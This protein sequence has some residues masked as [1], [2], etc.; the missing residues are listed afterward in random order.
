MIPSEEPEDLDQPDEMVTIMECLMP[1]YEVLPHTI[2]WFEDVVYE[3]AP[4]RFSDQFMKDILEEM[5]RCLTYLQENYKIV[6]VTV[7]TTK[8]EVVPRSV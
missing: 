4:H 6:E 2:S 7:T 8:K 3:I 5:K 1:Y